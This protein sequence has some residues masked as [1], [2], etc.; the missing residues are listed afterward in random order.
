MKTNRISPASK[1]ET[2]DKL[3]WYLDSSIRIPGTKWSVGFDGLL[4]L[5]PVIGDLTSG[6]IS[7]YIVLQGAQRGVS[8]TVIVKMLL[9]IGLDIAIGAIPIVGDIFDI[10]FK[11]N[12]RNVQLIHSYEH[13]PKKTNYKNRFSIAIFLITIISFIAFIF[14]LT[15]LILS[16]LLMLLV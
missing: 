12:Y 16:N 11:A 5:I 1:L 3:A 10:F 14:W 15:L 8:L 9:N 6:L 13:N 4:G 7:S 2:L